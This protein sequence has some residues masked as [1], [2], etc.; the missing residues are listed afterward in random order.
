MEIMKVLSP[1]EVFALSEPIEQSA[2]IRIMDDPTEV[3]EIEIFEGND[4]TL[5]MYQTYTKSFQCLYKLQKYPFDTQV[6]IGQ[7]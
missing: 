1:S 5:A 4:N 3:D 7:D 6:R 2:P